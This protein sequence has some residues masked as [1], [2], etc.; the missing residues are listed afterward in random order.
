MYLTTNGYFKSRGRRSTAAAMALLAMLLGLSACVESEAP[1]LDDG[2]PLL[3]ERIRLRI[4]SMRDGLAHEPQAATFRWKDGR[5]VPVGRFK[6]IEPFTL[7][8]FEGAD[9]IA[10][11]HSKHKK[12]EYGLVRKLAGGVFLV[13]PIDEDDADE[14]TRAKFC[15][16]DAAASCR[17]ESRDALLALARATGAKPHDRGGLAILVGPK[18]RP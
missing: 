7:H 15:R 2:K 6:D 16:K 3:G 11:S 17:I 18:A 10:Q 9:L 12:M 13:I 1:L 5:Y 8:A 4:Y 14:A